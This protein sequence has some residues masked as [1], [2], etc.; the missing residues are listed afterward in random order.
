MADFD[1]LFNNINALQESRPNDRVHLQAAPRQALKERAAGATP[2]DPGSIGRTSA[3]DTRVA[4]KL[5]LASIDGAAQYLADPVPGVGVVDVVMSDSGEVEILPGHLV[6]TFW[7]A[8]S[9]VGDADVDLGGSNDEADDEDPELSQYE[10][11]EDT[12]VLA[13]ILRRSW[14]C[15]SPRARALLRRAASGKGPNAQLL[16]ASGMI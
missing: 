11:I 8:G 4:A 14:L 10:E 13:E 15:P 6:S 2:S 12:E 1:S 9:D 5:G 3:T 16:R 7:V